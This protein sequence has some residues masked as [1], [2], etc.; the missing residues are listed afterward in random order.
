VQIGV[1]E[2]STDGLGLREV[3]ATLP[4]MAYAVGYVL[5]F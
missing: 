3:S 4:S 1:E 2:I 5:T